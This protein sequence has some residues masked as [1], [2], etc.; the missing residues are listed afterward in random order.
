MKSF[1]HLIRY[2]KKNSIKSL[3][4][5]TFLTITAIS[6]TS[7]ATEGS[8]AYD[9]LQQAFDPAIQQNV[10]VG[11]DS[12]GTD[13]ESVGNYVLNGGSTLNL[14]KGLTKR[15]SLIIEVTRFILRMS[16]VLAVTMLIY[17]GIQYMLK[18]S[19]GE[20]PKDIVTN[21]IYILA[22]VLLALSSVII[23]RLASSIGMS[24]LTDI[25]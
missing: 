2:I 19:K 23:I 8:N 24:S 20:H 3:I 14:K 12:I 22:G 11:G 16:I 13:V 15:Q 18:T 6:G 17:N 10:V 7:Y 25:I 5:S 21:I 1:K 4:F 9:L